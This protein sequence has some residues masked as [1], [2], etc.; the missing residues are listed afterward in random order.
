MAVISFLVS[1]GA[2]ANDACGI[3]PYFNVYADVTAGQC[4]PCLPLTCWPC[5]TTSQQLFLDS[6]LTTI[7]PDGYYMNEMSNNNYATWYVIGGYPQPAGF[8]SCSISPTVTPTISNTP[9]IT[10]TIT[11][12]PTSTLNNTPTPTPTITPTISLTPSITPTIS[13]TPSITPTISLTPS[14]TPFPQ[15]EVNFKTFADSFQLLS[16]AHKQLNSF[17]LGDVDTLSY[18]TTLR[19]KQDNTEFQPPIYPLLYVVPSKVTNDLQYKTWEFN[20]IVMDIVERDLDNQVDTVSDTLQILND[21]VSQFRYANTATFG[22]YYNKFWLDDSVICTPF[23]EKYHDL[24]N[25]WNGLLRVKTITPLDRCA[26]AYTTF[27]GTPVFHLDG[28]NFKTFHDDFRLLADHHKQINSFGFGALEDLSFW[29]ESRDKQQNT[30]YN[31]PIFPLMYVVPA[32]VFQNLSHMVYEFNV[33]ILDIIQRDLSNQVDVLSDTNQIL[34]DVISQFRLSVTNALGNFN[35]EYYLQTPVECFPFMEKYTDLCG[36]WNGVLRIEVNAPLDRCAAAFNS[37]LTPTPT[38]TPTNTPSPTISVTPTMT[39]TITSTETPIVTPTQT[40]TVSPTQT[41]TPTNTP[42]ITST[43]TPTVTP[44]QTP[45]ITPTITPS[46]TPSQTCPITTQ[47]LEVQLFESTKFKLI[48][49]NQ[50]DYTSPAVALCDY[51]ISGCAY[52][53]LGTIYCGTETILE[54]QHQHQ[55]NLAPVLLPGEIVVTFDVLSYTAT[56]CPCPVNLVLP[57]APTPTPTPTPTHTPTSTVTPTLTQT[58]TTT[59]TPTITATQ[60]QTPTPSITPTITPTVTITPTISL[61]PSTTP[62]LTPTPTAC[63]S[64]CCFQSDATSVSNFPI[65]LEFFNDGS[66]YVGCQNG[67]GTYLGTGTTYNNRIDKCGGLTNFTAYTTTCTQTTTNGVFSTIMDYRS[68]GKYV[69][70]RDRGRVIFG[71]ASDYSID[72]TFNQ[73]RW[74]TAG[75]NFRRGAYG[76]Y[77]N[78]SDQVYVMGLF[79]GWEMCSGGTPFTGSTNIV[80]LN[81]NGDIDRTYSGIN[82]GFTSTTTVY[83]NSMTSNNDPNGKCLILRATGFTGN[84]TYRNVFRF[85]ENGTPDDTFSSAIWSGYSTDLLYCSYALS[86]GKYLVG[87]AFTNVGGNANQ[88]FLVRLNSDGSLDTSFVYG[89]TQTVWDIDVDV[90]GNIY[91][92][93][94]DRVRKLNSNGTLLATRTLSAQLASIICNDCEVFVGGTFSATIGGVTYNYLIKLNPDLT[95]NMCVYP[96]PTP[97]RT[98]TQTPTPTITPS[99]SP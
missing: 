8:T 47:Y 15:Q 76:L 27:T 12:T 2:T 33:I 66:L 34:D 83:E 24:T 58:P 99:V 19:D 31:S 81:S 97:T 30:E 23:L 26:A 35:K 56:T 74:Y 62:T 61:T 36:G 48:L 10:P 69:A 53:S 39:P 37:F 95:P 71:I 29:T 65:S 42:T 1:S 85:N 6:G 16:E 79:D 11:N 93:E 43:E 18:W 21:V 73:S 98:P 7:V 82:L 22:D 84:T 3:G 67:T 87:G 28:I 44:T 80:R 70:T 64:G 9:T 78:S 57:I 40:T 25:G 92:I 50:P 88:D 20:S 45:T 86:N 59:Q 17:G 41:Q 38:N 55:F 49:W 94:V 72:T 32:N 90:Y 77:V 89:G 91:V 96:T 51:V 13:L 52:G 5:L 75:S 4:T 63:Y 68:G 54:G 60:T 46:I 14:N